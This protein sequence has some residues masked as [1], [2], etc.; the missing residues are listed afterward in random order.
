ML[1]PQG[2]TIITCKIKSEILTECKN[3]FTFFLQRPLKQENIKLLLASLFNHISFLKVI[4]E[5]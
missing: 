2:P 4:F 5:A 3:N 1:L